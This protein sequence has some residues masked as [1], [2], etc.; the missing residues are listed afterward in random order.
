MDKVGKYF[1][2]IIQNFCLKLNWLI[3]MLE[4]MQFLWI[5]K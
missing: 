2:R 5:C 4:Q 3:Y 1:A